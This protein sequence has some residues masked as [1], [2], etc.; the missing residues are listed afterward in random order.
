MAGF[1]V[2]MPTGARQGVFGLRLASGQ[3][4]AT[5]ATTT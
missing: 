3:P 1:E 5:K 2:P 4:P